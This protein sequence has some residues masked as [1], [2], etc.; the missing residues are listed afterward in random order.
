VTVTFYIFMFGI[1][2][3]VPEPIWFTKVQSK[4]EPS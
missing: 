1:Y 2:A 3:T 4:S